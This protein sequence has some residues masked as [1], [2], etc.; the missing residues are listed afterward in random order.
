MNEYSLAKVQLF[1][2]HNTYKSFSLL[3]SLNQSNLFNIM[4]ILKNIYLRI[5][6]VFGA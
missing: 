2:Y 3:L 4:V 1:I 5:V 6:I